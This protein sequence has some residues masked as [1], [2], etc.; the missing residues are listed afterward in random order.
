MITVTDNAPAG[1]D[2]LEMILSTITST[3]ETP[4]PVIKMVMN[5]GAYSAA[6][7]NMDPDKTESV[8]PMRPQNT[9]PRALLVRKGKV[10]KDTMCMQNVGTMRD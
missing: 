1:K 3:P 6:M 4:W 9:M 7:P 8:N 5:L 10:D 2:A